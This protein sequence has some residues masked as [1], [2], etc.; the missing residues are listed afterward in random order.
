MV[1]DEQW[2]RFGLRILGWLLLIAF[3]SHCTGDM[4]TATT[5]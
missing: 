4:M 2:W 5:P 1:E 3:V